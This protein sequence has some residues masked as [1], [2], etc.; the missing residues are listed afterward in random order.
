MN[1]RQKQLTRRLDAIQ[2]TDPHYIN[3]AKL[4]ITP[5]QYIEQRKQ[6][7]ETSMEP[8]WIEFRKRRHEEREKRDAEHALRT[9]NFLEKRKAELA[10]LDQQEATQN[11]TF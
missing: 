7:M 1:T 8:K 6:E 9:R 2:E 11:R 5:Q 4:G 10:E 3:F